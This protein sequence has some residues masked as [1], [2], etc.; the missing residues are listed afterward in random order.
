MLSDMHGMRKA[1]Q[2]LY[3]VNRDLLAEHAKRSSNH[4][5]LLEALKD[6]NSMIQ[7]AARLRM[8]TAKTQF[9]TSC[10]QML[11]TNN[12]HSLLQIMQ[13]GRAAR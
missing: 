6:V 7:K 8:G 10:R 12:I 11:K 13:T 2:S 3:G 1:Y 9:V 4:K 5:A